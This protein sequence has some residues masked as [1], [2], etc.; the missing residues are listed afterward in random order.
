MISIKDNATCLKGN[1]C[2]HFEGVKQPND[3]ESIEY[4]YCKAFP[5]GIPDEI[6]VEGYDHTK[7]FKGDKG[8]KFEQ[9]E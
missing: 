2:K 9:Q 8:I 1:T 7:E 6:L 4:Y 3:D 5:Y